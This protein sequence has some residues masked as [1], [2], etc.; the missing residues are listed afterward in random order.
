MGT[1]SS[2]EPSV[3][4]LGFKPE[5]PK[6][7]PEVKRAKKPRDDSSE[8][9]AKRLAAVEKR[10]ATLLK[11]AGLKA[12]PAIEPLIAPASPKPEPTTAPL[13]VPKP[14]PTPPKSE[15]PKSEPPKPEPPK[16]EPTTAPLAEKKD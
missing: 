14:E 15:P 3:E 12:S 5:T 11:K 4:P 2:K 16:P 13:S 1:E 6:A 7:E 10:R 9:V 8:A